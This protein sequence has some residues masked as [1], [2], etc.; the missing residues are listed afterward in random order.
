MGSANKNVVG[1]CTCFRCQ[2]MSLDLANARHPVRFAKVKL[3]VD[4]QIMFWKSSVDNDQSPTHTWAIP[5]FT[6]S[7]HMNLSS[8]TI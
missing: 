7:V 4:T 5:S 1:R 2:I 8:T 3:G 6:T